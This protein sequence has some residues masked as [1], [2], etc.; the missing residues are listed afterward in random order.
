MQE[1]LPEV[2]EPLA[3]TMDIF[4]TLIQSVVPTF[5]GAL[6]G[7]LFARRKQKAEARQ[8]ELDTV[9]KAV[10]IWR[11]VAEGLKLELQVQREEIAVL[12]SKIEALHSD[13][14][15]LLGELKKFKKQTSA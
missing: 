7:W 4:L 5:I 11:E 3:P 13:N 1:V 8:S 10:A 12:R 2:I 9:E 6:S 14:T 15:R